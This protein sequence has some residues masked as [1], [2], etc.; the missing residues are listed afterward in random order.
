MV[1]VCVGMCW[2]ATRMRVVVC[3]GLYWL[4]ALCAIPVRIGFFWHV[5]V[6]FAPP[7][8][9]GV[10]AIHRNLVVLIVLVG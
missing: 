6:M 7:V 8:V 9:C 5:V 10:I 4:C 1:V 2:V 3:V